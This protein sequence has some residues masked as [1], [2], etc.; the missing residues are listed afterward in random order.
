MRSAFLD[1]FKTIS[2]DSF[3]E[4]DVIVVSSHETPIHGFEKLLKN[5]ILSAPVFD[6][7]TKQYIGFL[8]VRDL[9]SYAVFAF[10][11]HNTIAYKGLSQ[12]PIF[13]T[14]VD[15]V[16]VTYLARRNPF[17]SVPI[18][19]SLY[20]VAKMLKDG[21]H[22][23]PV[24]DPATGAV[25]KI[26][27]QSSVIQVLQQQ[28]NGIL[29][30]VVLKTVEELDLGTSPV[31]CVQKD[32]LAIDTFKLMDDTKKTAVALVDEHGKL[33]GNTSAKDLKLFIG[34]SCSY[35]IL[36]K[37]IMSFLNQIRDE[38]IDIPIPTITCNMKSPLALVIGKL[39]ATRVHRLYVVANDHDYT[40]QRVVSLTDILKFIF[41][42]VS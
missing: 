9:V 23:V 1:Y 26:I 39:A 21:I 29:K 16:T 18:G 15:D 42:G 41:K 33:V 30:D 5:N 4:R 13:H 35:D 17:K 11:N 6:E 25:V 36:K 12:G 27:S 8:D 38:N 31:V 37:T 40:P 10:N 19:S 32:T 2:V 22:R 24:V 3:P 28:L 14:L 34:S 7:S 20:E